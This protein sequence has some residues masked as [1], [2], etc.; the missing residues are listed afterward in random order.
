MPTPWG[1]A[2]S[3]LKLASPAFDQPLL[4]VAGPAMTTV[5]GSGGKNLL[6]GQ[7]ELPSPSTAAP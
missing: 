4:S 6:R 7:A 2:S 5:C 1:E 3:T